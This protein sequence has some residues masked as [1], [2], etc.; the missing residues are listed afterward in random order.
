VSAAL[1]ERLGALGLIDRVDAWVPF[2]GGR[3]NRAWQVGGCDGVVVKLFGARHCNPLFPNDAG[4][5]RQAL[6]WLS[7]SG[8][9]PRLRHAETEAEPPLIVYDHVA[10]AEWAADPTPVAAL[11]SRLHLVPPPPGLRR[12]PGGSARL[13]AEG[14]RIL[15]LCP[16][17][18]ERRRLI[19]ACPDG[20][21]VPPSDRLVFLHGDPVPGNLI[22]TPDGPVLI[23]WQ[24]PAIG[25]PVEDIAIFLSPSMQILYRGAALSPKECDAFLAGI[26]DRSVAIRYRMMAPWYHWRMATYC[27]WRGART[28]AREAQA[29]QAE[30][31]ALARY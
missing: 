6:D 8:I 22:L 25:D 17:S 26:G 13:R 27:L 31:S 20:P 29:M 14:M 3:S 9:A 11:L 30:L 2:H 10:G 4:S 15:G 12:C 18:A 21:A 19:A 1:R 24:C 16:E 5:E 28:C 23:D 7:G